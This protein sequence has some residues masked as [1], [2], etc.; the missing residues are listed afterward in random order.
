MDQPQTLDEVLKEL[1][2]HYCDDTITPGI[3][4][5]YLP[6]DNLFYAAVHQFPAGVASRKVVAKAKAPTSGLAMA[7]CLKTWRSIVKAGG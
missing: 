6:Q 4:V 1:C 7:E 3:Q 2:T 5:A